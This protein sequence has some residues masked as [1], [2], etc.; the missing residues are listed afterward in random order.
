[1]NGSCLIITSRNQHVIKHPKISDDSIL[2]DVNFLKV[3]DAK[4]LFYHHAFGLDKVPPSHLLDSVTRIVKKCQGLPLTLEVLG[5]YLWGNTGTSDLEIWKDTIKC[6]DDAEAVEGGDYNKVWARLRISYD[7][8]LSAEEKE[9]FIDAETFFFE[10]PPEEALAAWSTA[11]GMFSVRW[12]N[13]LNISMVKERKRQSK[14]KYI[15][16]HEHLC[17]LANKISKGDEPSLSYGVNETSQK[18][19]SFAQIWKVLIFGLRR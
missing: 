13:L 7:K 6:L 9:M 12:R 16:V 8:K 3:D 11:Y 1:V 19:I 2:F 18:V 5:C 15:W 4:K 14:A 10:K 17:D